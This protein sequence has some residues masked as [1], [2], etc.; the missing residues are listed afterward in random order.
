MCNGAPSG[1]RGRA[2]PYAA[3]PPGG[4]TLSNVTQKL[5]HLKLDPK[6]DGA[7]PEKAGAPGCSPAMLIRIRF[8]PSAGA[9]R[10]QRRTRQLALALGALLSPAA[11]VALALACWRLGAD[12]N[13]TGRFAISDGLFSHWQ[14][15][16]FVAG[17]LEAA[18]WALNR[19]LHSSEDSPRSQRPY[20]GRD[21][22]MP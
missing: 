9:L 5:I 10:G 19:R 7:P 14:V 6:A 15:W 16:L 3:P 20:G 21:Q 17:L 22:A 2:C 12:L 18:A 8:R 1:R 4:R 13:L 11:V